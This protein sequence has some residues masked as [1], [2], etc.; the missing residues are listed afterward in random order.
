MI[1]DRWFM[2]GLLFFARIALGF[3]FQSAGSVAPFLVRDFG[4]DYAQVGTLIGLYMFP[5]VV[6]AIPSGILGR[7]LGDKCVVLAGMALMIVG[8]ATAGLESSYATV[9]FGRLMSGIG[10]SFLVV[11]MTKMVTDWFAEKE[12]FFGMPIYII[13]WP[14]GI[15]AGQ[16]SQG[17]LAEARS[18]NL[19]FELTACLVTMSFAAM[20]I[21][22]R[23][24]PPVS[25]TAPLEK[26][27]LSRRETWLIC[28]AGAMWA[29]ANAAY[30]VILSF[31]PTLLMEQG[32]SVVEAGF[33][34]SLMSWISIGALPLGGYLTVRYKTPDLMMA[35]S[36][37]AT[38][39]IGTLIPL[40]MAPPEIIFILFGISYSFAI[41]AIAS[42]PAQLLAPQNRATGLGVYW[43]LFYGGVPLITALSGLMKDI[44]GSAA[45]SI[46]FAAAIILLCV[47]LLLLLRFERARSV[48]IE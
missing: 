11:P 38:A 1:E 3:Q 20:G 45:F 8:G 33:A 25:M 5:G 19:V 39:C 27:S 6:V 31:G 2:L 4:I 21:L 46:Y 28:I 15:A 24:P 30:L 47:G 48:V 23:Q 32:E 44:L 18:W 14:I 29:F 9:V 26:G 40:A 16:A 17:W 42:L 7:R 13:G 36:L 37:T 34:V 12:L 41:P 43:A 10:A 22:Y 35:C